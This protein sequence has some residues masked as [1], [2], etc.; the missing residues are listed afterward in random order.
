MCKTKVCTSCKE[1]KEIINFGTDNKR[2]D[3]LRGRCKV[4]E[5]NKILFQKTKPLETGI[6]R[7]CKACLE[8]KDLCEFGKNTA[9]KDGLQAKC[10]KCVLT[11]NKIILKFEPIGEEQICKVCK[12]SK[13]LSL[14][15]T[16]NDRVYKREKRC[17]ECCS[18]NLYIDNK[19]FVE[20]TKK[21]SICKVYKPF[22]NYQKCTSCSNG[23]TAHCK[24]CDT[25]KSKKY[26]DSISEVEKKRRKREDYEKNKQSYIERARNWT[27][28][29]RERHNETI[30]IRTKVRMIEEPLYKLKSNIS[31]LIRITFTKNLGGVYPKKS[32][33]LDILGCTLEEFKYHIESQFLNWMNWDNQGNCE[34]NEYN[35]TWHF[36]HIIPISVACTEEEV[37]MLNH[38][39]N[40]QPLCSKV[41]QKDKWDKVYPLT[42]LELKITIVEDKQIIYN[43]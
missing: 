41:N 39:S 5:K 42:N 4:C 15:P 11:N 36:D 10:N 14:F 6:L 29:N 37:Y 23:I 1:E 16:R 17:R 13:D 9:Y 26:R 12:I 34:T 21:C 3:N 30:K 35:C 24:E 27:N 28:N 18:S 38:W 20:D 8:T 25:I 31:S 7:V 40:F 43:D 33:T 2:S 32:K 22:D 19:I